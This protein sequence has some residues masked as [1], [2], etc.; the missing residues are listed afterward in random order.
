ML[1]ILW[2]EKNHF[3]SEE[4]CIW[5]LSGSNNVEHK[6]LA[7]TVHLAIYK[8]FAHTLSHWILATTLWS[9]T[10]I[11]TVQ[12]TILGLRQ[13]HTVHQK[14]KSPSKKNF[15][16]SKKPKWYYRSSYFRISI[17]NKNLISGI[18]RIEYFLS[19][20]LYSI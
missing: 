17:S 19:N 1:V 16:N 12:N 6:Y 8:A 20:H 7:F 5:N 11:T 14:W 4:L 2:N 10:G 3:C 13:D 15:P 9:R 18:S